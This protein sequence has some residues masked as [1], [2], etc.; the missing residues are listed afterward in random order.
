MTWLG[1]KGRK[2]GGEKVEKQGEAEDE[3]R[4]RHV[5]V[6][7]WGGRVGQNWESSVTRGASNWP[8]NFVDA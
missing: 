2:N 1:G 6:C 3:R 5:C 8:L 7:V 4:E